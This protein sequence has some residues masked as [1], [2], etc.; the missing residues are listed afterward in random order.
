M[1]VRHKPRRAFT[2]IEL[3]VVIAIIA[4]LIGILLPALSAA[5]GAARDAKCKSNLRQIGIAQATYSNDNQDFFVPAR[6]LESVSGVDQEG[7]YAAILTFKGYGAA[8]DVLNDDGNSGDTMFRCPE[9]IDEEIDDTILPAD[10]R[11]VEGLHYWRGFYIRSGRIEGEIDTWYGANS[12]FMDLTGGFQYH[13]RFPLSDV[14]DI[15]ANPPN[16]VVQQ[17]VPSP[18]NIIEVVKK[19]TQTVLFYDGIKLHNG[20]WER[21][22][23]RH[24]GSERM[25]LNFADGHVEDAGPDDVPE[26]GDTIGGNTKGSIGDLA[27][28]PGIRWRLD[29]SDT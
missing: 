28:Y 11:A 7:S 22:S 29:D 27:D 17:F 26:P 16:A 6:T 10:R 12:M 19:P 1:P 25:N 21:L 3:L 14:T 9:G 18:L 5:R 2:L 13:Q 23:L 15:V 4:L 20:T 24:G 8:Q